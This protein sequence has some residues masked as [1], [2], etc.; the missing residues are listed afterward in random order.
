VPIIFGDEYDLKVEMWCWSQIAGHG[1]I[2]GIG[3]DGFSLPLGMHT[4]IADY[5]STA[6][7]DGVSLLDDEGNPVEGSATVGGDDYTGSFTA[8]PAPELP[9]LTQ[10]PEPAALAL[11]V[12]ATACLATRLRRRR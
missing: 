3:G 4:V 11:L 1:S 8:P 6:T 12:M 10:I 5:H 9:P 2:A 7:W